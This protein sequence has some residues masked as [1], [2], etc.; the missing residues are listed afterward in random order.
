MYPV[1]FTETFFF[2]LQSWN[3]KRNMATISYEEFKT[4]CME[5]LELSKK[6]GDTWKLR[7]DIQDKDGVCIH[8]IQCIKNRSSDGH[9]DKTASKG[10]GQLEME[11][12][13]ESSDPSVMETHH[14]THFTT[15]DYHI[16]YSLSHFVP[17]L[18][19]NAW[20]SSGQLLTLDEVWEGVD[21][22]HREQILNNKWGTL[23]QTEHP[24]LGRPY[25]QLHPCNTAKLMGQVLPQPACGP[26][27]LRMYL[28]SWLSMF[29]PPVG[30]ELTLCY[31]AEQE[32]AQSGCVK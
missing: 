29:G 18:Y 4:A 8:K 31:F 12:K 5:F 20:H 23:T 16:V 24:L 14:T 21:V 7:S 3:L 30:L 22:T 19:F 26:A 32:N 25:F 2:S 11:E 9:E 27:A 10:D 28:I 6:L 17:V 1:V 13:E 15:Y